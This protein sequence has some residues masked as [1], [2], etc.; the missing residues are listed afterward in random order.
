MPDLRR[1]NCINCGDHESV[2][3]PISWRGKCQPCALRLE[4]QAIVDMATHS[5]PT[6][7]LWRVRLAASVGAVLTD[8]TRMRS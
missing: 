3:G 1:R 2:C 7:Q 4:E 8:D 6:F 5:G